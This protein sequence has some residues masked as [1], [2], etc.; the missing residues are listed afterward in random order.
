MNRQQ[1]RISPA[2]FAII[3]SLATAVLL[4]VDQLVYPLMSWWLLLVVALLGGIV[5]FFATVFD[6]A[7]MCGDGIPRAM[8]YRCMTWAAA[9]TWAVWVDVTGLTLNLGIAWAVGTAALAGIGSFCGVPAVDRRPQ[10][11]DVPAGNDRRPEYVRTW[12]GY[13][14]Q[15]T[16][17]KTV[18]ISRWERW[19]VEA[20]G[21]RLWVDLPTETGNTDADLADICHRLGAAARLKNGCVVQALPSEV[22]GVA[23]LDVML[24]DNLTDTDN[25][26]HVEP[27]TP[28]SITEEFTVLTTPRGQDLK[29]GLRIETM[30]I[31][32]ATGSGKTTL[33]NRIIM[34]LARCTDTLIW[35]VDLNGGGIANNWIEPYARGK[36]SKPVVD[37]VAHTEE[38]F[39]VMVAVAGAIARDRKS[40]REAR[41]RIRR[42]NS[43]GVLPVDSRM[44]AIIVLADEGGEIRQSLTA[45]GQIAAQALTRLAQIGRAAG[46]RPIISILRGTSD[47][48]DKAHRTQC[49]IR[50]C[51]RMNEHSEYVH[52]LDSNPG[53]TP[54]KHKGSGY[55]KTTFE[56]VEPVYGRTVNVDELSIERH[57]I[58]CAELRPDLDSNGLA[59]AEKLRVDDVIG[60]R[61]FPSFVKSR[62]YQDILD[63][64]AYSGRWDRAAA[65]LAELRGEDYEEEQPAEVARPAAVVRDQ[66]AAGALDALEAAFGLVAKEDQAGQLLHFP[67][68]PGMDAQPEERK[69]SGRDQVLELIRAAGPSGI[70]SKAIG[71]QV[72]ISRAQV[73]NVL[74]ELREDGS[75]TQLQPGLYAV[76]TADAST[77]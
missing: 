50:L 67:H 17:W 9:G 73:F 23:I 65:L 41:E 44:P 64:R 48:M 43:G 42:A 63:G 51:L 60:G 38:E 31:G 30:L 16:R 25:A 46:V 69:G 21:F 13:I 6:E 75:V 35:V 53:K 7:A 26:V 28:A 57:A 11:V 10:P 45:L 1:E 15:V 24:R 36:A 33:L 77:A 34:F 32:G 52:V 61:D 5:S 54:L 29:V 12:E 39:A 72:T 59:V 47:L 66:K 40:N 74:R 19:E 58:A 49:A 27:T 20:D 62:V 18:T 22:Q 4:I 37:W 3:T 8:V 2:W 76:S 68:R 55:L 71:E 14:R 56:L 70:E